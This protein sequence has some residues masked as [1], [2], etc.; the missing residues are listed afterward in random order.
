[1]IASLT[2]NAYSLCRPFIFNISHVIIK[3][4]NYI[5]Y[6]R[7]KEEVLKFSS[8]RCLINLSLNLNIW[9]KLTYCYLSESASSINLLD[10]FHTNF[11]TVKNSSCSHE[12]IVFFWIVSYIF[13]W[14]F[15]YC[16]NHFFMLCYQITNLLCYILRYHNNSDVISVK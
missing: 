2:M 3:C 1:M 14:D 5:N 10:F 12:N 7:D 13:A 16:R 8:Y 6:N 15:H 4:I 11:V 9:N